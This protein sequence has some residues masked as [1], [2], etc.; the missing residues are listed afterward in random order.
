ME[1]KHTPV[2]NGMTSFWR[3]EPHFLDSHRST[4]SL[5]REC[6]IVVVGAG[7]A[8]ASVVHHILDQLSP[9]STPP[10]IV[11]L[12]ARQACS[13]A[14]GRNGGHMKPDVYNGIASL[15]VDHGV[16]AAAE[17][18]AFEAKHISFLK[19]FVER[20]KI[21][22]EYTVTKAID[23][24]LSRSYSATL[25]KAYD[26]LIEKGCEATTKAKYIPRNEAE[27]FSGVKGAQGCFT[28]DAGHIWPYK[29]V[30]HLLE[31]AIAKGVNLQTH[32]PVSGITK[33]T[34]STSSHPWTVN[35]ARGSVA[36]KTV[37][38]ATNAYTSSL[39]PQYK[40]KI[41]PV[42]GTCS[43][44]V[45]PRGSTAPPLTNT[46]TLRWNNWNYDYLI[47]RADGSIVVGGARPAFIDDLDSW[48]NVSDD[49]LVL[50][51]AVRYW[52]NY[53]QRN[54]VGWENS[55][56]YT[57]RVWTG[58]MGYS[59]DGLPHIG[60]VP[61]QKDQYII[62]GFTGHGMP[63]IFLAA[64]GLA[65]MVLNDIDFAQTRLPRLFESTQSRLDSRQNKIF[66]STPGAGKPQ[67]R[68]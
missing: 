60:L 61:G 50:E 18:A 38:L 8:G 27:K 12:E 6:D 57:D 5:P 26:G 41:I 4:E 58:I 14:T 51:P 47:P 9:G 13:G 44:I 25:K 66:D 21:D 28:Y 55:H 3:T 32:T 29:F 56:A 10:S 11:I 16:E 46:Y 22:C 30:L 35:T 49:S 62:A 43:R 52:D 34:P 42:R 31:K 59:S 20:E 23:V 64:E 15:A 45:V 68:L 53:M 54:F 39:A 48:Y 24:Q 1:S 36:A 40:E 17:V 7:Y 65:K 67:A 37:V 33:S 63:Q 2:P 19:E